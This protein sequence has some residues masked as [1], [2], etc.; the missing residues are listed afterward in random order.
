MLSRRR[1]GKTEVQRPKKCLYGCVLLGA[2]SRSGRCRRRA[3]RR[4][5]SREA[6][7]DGSGLERYGRFGMGDGAVKVVNEAEGFA[8]PKAG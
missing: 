6:G 1:I 7:V 2:A 3:E 4:I 5:K 8:E